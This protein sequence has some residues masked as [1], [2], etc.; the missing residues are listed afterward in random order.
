M[1]CSPWP[2]W[3]PS[4]PLPTA[5]SPTSNPTS[6]RYVR[7]DGSDGPGQLALLILDAHAMGVNPKAFGATDLVSCLLATERTSGTDKVLFGAQDAT[8]DGAYRQGL[9]LAALAG[10]RCD[11]SR[12][13]WDRP[14]VGST[15]NSAPTEAGRA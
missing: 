3:E 4:R 6:T 11:E 2:V 5:P 8:Y 10:C 9:S 14:S 15:D 1:W 12:H 13:R 7:V